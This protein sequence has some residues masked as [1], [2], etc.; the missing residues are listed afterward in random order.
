[1]TTDLESREEIIGTCLNCMAWDREASNAGL[2]RRVPP[3]GN[4]KGSMSRYAEWPRTEAD[5]WCMS[6]I[7]GPD[8]DPDEDRG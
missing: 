1:M 5:D 3:V 2:C 8:R 6:W 4:V 7:R